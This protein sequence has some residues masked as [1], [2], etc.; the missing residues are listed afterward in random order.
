MNSPVECREPGKKDVLRLLKL[1]SKRTDEGL[2]VRN[3]GG[4]GAIRLEFGEA[5]RTIPRDVVGY[6]RR[7]RLAHVRSGK[8]FISFEGLKK[9]HQLCGADALASG[10]TSQTVVSKPDRDGVPAIVNLDESP[11]SRLFRRNT[12]TGNPYIDEAEFNAG[13]R[14]RRD[15]EIAQLQPRIT[16]NYAYSA[17][18]SGKGGKFQAAELSDFAIDARKRIDRAMNGLDRNLAGVALDVCCFLKGLETVERERRWPP[19]SAKLML[20]T[21]LS[22]LAVHYGYAGNE[23]R[24]ATGILKWNDK[25][26]RPELR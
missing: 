10:H 16:A 26:Y 17:G 11:L 21:G 23:R 25:G 7:N 1:L 8:I 4:D 9:L 3:E 5:S 24:R 13:E 14:L 6:A 12:K 20:K 19:R 22:I 18:S 15:F 2:T